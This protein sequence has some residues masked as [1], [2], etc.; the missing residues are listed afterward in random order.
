MWMPSVL[1][2]IAAGTSA[3]RVNRAVLRLCR[4]LIPRAWS[5][6]GEGVIPGPLRCGPTRLATYVM[7]RAGR[8]P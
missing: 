8:G 4:G 7:R 3:A 1:V 6:W 2:K 5:R